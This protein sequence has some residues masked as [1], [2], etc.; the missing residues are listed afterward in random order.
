MEHN[1]QTMQNGFGGGDVERMNLIIAAATELVDDVLDQVHWM[2]DPRDH[3]II[4]DDNSMVERDGSS[5]VDE[6]LEISPRGLLDQLVD[7]ITVY[8]AVER[9]NSSES[10]VTDDIHGD[11]PEEILL[12]Q[13]DS[14]RELVAVSTRHFLEDRA[15][16]KQDTGVVGMSGSELVNETAVEETSDPMEP[17]DEVE[18]SSSLWSDMEQVICTE[19][20]PKK[21]RSFLS[22]L[23]R[24]LLSAG[25]KL[26][27][28]GGGRRVRRRATDTPLE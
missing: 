18:N 4:V 5:I 17:T 21:R 3:S 2:L 8:S 28:C 13:F 12:H 10:D 9:M 20:T 16:L 22:A 6:S 11:D 7:E 25:R 23:G 15:S 1:R 26:F 14:S 27:C 24:R 19:P